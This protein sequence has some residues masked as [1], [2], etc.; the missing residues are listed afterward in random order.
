MSLLTKVEREI[1]LNAKNIPGWKSKRKIVVFECDDY[2]GIRMPSQSV[3][4]KLIERGL[5][6]ATS[7][8]NI[9]DTLETAEDL[10]YL[11]TIL[12]S[13]KDYN[14]RHAVFSPMTIVANPDFESIE[15]S[16]FS[17]YACEPFDKTLLSYYPGTKVLELWR[18]GIDAGIFIPGLHGRDHTTVQLWLRNLKD[19]D[20]DLAFAFK[21]RFVSLSVPGIPPAADEFRAEYFHTSPE[22]STFLKRRYPRKRLDF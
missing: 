12:T 18:H 2:G 13:V 21:N 4:N 20:K 16:G 6:V 15:S 8:F 19:G 11:F 7:R 22:E 1:I 9:F 3:F 5:R 14:S 17:S 10:D